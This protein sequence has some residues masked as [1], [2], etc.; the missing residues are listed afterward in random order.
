MYAVLMNKCTRINNI[1]D[2]Y[3]SDAVFS[4]HT[5]QTMAYICLHFVV[6]SLD[7]EPPGSG[8]WGR[9]TVERILS[10][11]RGTERRA[12]GRN[13]GKRLRAAPWAAQGS[14]PSRTWST[15]SGRRASR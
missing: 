4:V 5:V 14:T 6:A 7:L 13:R 8:N 3:E 15:P 12:A 10:P 1:V 11:R 9:S 2:R